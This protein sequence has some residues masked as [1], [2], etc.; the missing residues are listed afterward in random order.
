MLEI[1]VTSPEQLAAAGAT[2]A[3]RWDRLDGLLHAIGFAPPDCLGSGMFAAD[4][5]DVSV[6]LHISTYSLKAL[7]DAFLPLLSAAGSGRRGLRRRPR[8]RRQR[9]VAGL[10]LDGRG[11][12]G[13]RVALPLPGQGARAARHPGEPG[14]GRAG[15]G[16]M[17]AKSI[18]GF[19]AFED[20]WADLPRWAGTC[21]TPTV[22]A[23]ACLA[24][25][26]R[27]VPDDDRRDRPRRRR[28]PRRGRV[29]LTTPF[30]QP[31]RAARQPP[32]ATSRPPA[33]PAVPGS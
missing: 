27:P 15:A 23:K 29:R 3:D 17:A 16:R 18:P 2:L 33:A 1:D 11:Q 12:G 25:L 26:Q 5:D 4:W 19:S 24:L 21:T 30:R 22:V 13:A 32:S 7:V 6:A 9:G 10:R 14:G 31:P 8:L 20:T 28:G